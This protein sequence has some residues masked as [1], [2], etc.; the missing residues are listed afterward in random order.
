[1]LSEPLSAM[2]MDVTAA[3]H[4]ASSGS[5]YDRYSQRLKEEQRPLNSLEIDIENRG[6]VSVDIKLNANHESWL[7]RTRKSPNSVI[8]VVAIALFADMASYDMLVPI[9]PS[10]LHM[11]GKDIDM[12]G[13]L[14]S[15][16]SIGF[17]IGT[18]VLG[19]WSD[20]LRDRQLPM[21]LGQAGL[22]L[23]TILFAFSTSFYMLMFARF[24][25]GVAAAST[26]TL[27]LALLAD[28]IPQEHLGSAMGIVFGCS[29]LGYFVGPLMSGILAQLV[30]I[31]TPFYFCATVC[32]IGLGLL[33][34]LLPRPPKDED[35][36]GKRAT[37]T[38]LIKVP[39]IA[40]IAGIVMMSAAS[41]SAVETLLSAHLQNEFK[42]DVMHVSFCM[43]AIIFPSVI[44][45]FIGGWVSDNYDR[46]KMM[47]WGLCLYGMATPFLGLAGSLPVFLLALAYFGATSSIIQAPT[48]Q[49]VESVVD[50][51]GYS[52]YAQAYAILNVAY[53]LGMLL[54][55][56]VAGELFNLMSFRMTMVLFIIPI[57]SLVPPLLFVK[58]N[59]VKVK[60]YPRAH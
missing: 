35:A 6:S 31:K 21:A 42:L 25:Q 56:L 12:L 7:E 54:G 39:E 33:F 3:I 58:S 53:S 29:N 20:K 19:V 48:Y 46:Y 17:L 45:S 32:L 16:Y 4:R 36:P 15:V 27:G 26:W 57:I 34:F 47:V 43:L 10:L 28:N 51:L 37:I 14:F 59:S 23:A 50:Y 18:P 11:V 40:M 2:P 60:T 41:S 5:E 44:F 30:D 22:G 38:K 13:T 49:E 24:L 52:S 9:L 1:M 8:V 55:P